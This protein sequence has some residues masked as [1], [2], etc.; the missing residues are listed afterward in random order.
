MRPPRVNAG[1]DEVANSEARKIEPIAVKVKIRAM[2]STNACGE[3]FFFIV[4]G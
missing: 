1:L 3:V 2:R 4:L